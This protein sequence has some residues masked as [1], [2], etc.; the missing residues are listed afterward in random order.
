MKKRILSLLLALLMVVSMIP[1][2]IYATE[3]EAEGTPETVIQET[4]EP[5]PEPAPAPSQTPTPAPTETPAAPVAAAE[6]SPSPSQEVTPAPSESA[7][8][9]EEVTPAPTESSAPS[10]EE[11]PVPTDGVTASPVN[12]PAPTEEA[13]PSPSAEPEP[14]PEQQPMM[15]KIVTL[16]ANPGLL[17]PIE[18]PTVS[19]NGDIVGVKAFPER[20]KIEAVETVGNYTY[21]QLKAADGNWPDY[22]GVVYEHYWLPSTK[23]EEVKCPICEKTGCTKEHKKCETCGEY[24]CESTHENW[25]DICKKDD[26]GQNHIVDLTHESTGVAVY[27]TTFPEGVSLSVSSANVSGQLSTFGIPAS[28]QV[29]GLDISLMREDGTQYQPSNYVL[30]KVP[31][32][33]PAGTYVGILHT[34]NGNTTFLTFTQVLSDGT[35]EFYTR[36]FSEFAGFTVD[37]HYN[38]IDYSIGGLTSITLSE[39][40]PIL[41]IDRSAA[42]AVSVEFSDPTLISVTQIENDWRLES[43][44]A[45]DTEE[46]LTVTFADG[47]IIVIDVTD[48]KTSSFDFSSYGINA[49]FSSTGLGGSR[50]PYLYLYWGDNGS[51]FDHDQTTGVITNA[52]LAIYSDYY[53]FEIKKFEYIADRSDP[54]TPFSGELGGHPGMNAMAMGT[55]GIGGSP[56]VHVKVWDRTITDGTN[57][58]CSIEQAGEFVAKGDTI[59]RNVKIYLDG[60]E[61]QTISN[62]LFPHRAVGSDDPNGILASDLTTVTSNNSSYFKRGDV[63]GSATVVAGGDTYHVYLVTRGTVQYDANGGSGAP[64]SQY[65]Y[66]GV[67]LTL[68]STKPTKAYSTFKGWATTK[69]RADAGT[70]DYAAGATYTTNLSSGSSTTLYAVWE[71]NDANYTVKHMKQNVAGTGYDEVTGDRQTLTA[72][73]YAS[74]TPSVKSY[75]GFDSPATQTVTVNGDGSTVI[76]YK[77]NRKSYTVT[78][79]KG[80]GISAVSGGGTYKYGANVTVGATVSSG[81]TWKNWTSG[82]SQVSATQSYAFTMPAGNVTYTANAE[83][84]PYTIIYHLDNGTATNPGSY[85]IE[86][87]AFTLNNPEKTGYDFAGWT[88]TGLSGKTMTVTISKGSTGNRAYTANWTPKIF[89]VTLDDQG[90]TTSGTGEYWYKFNTVENGV[91]YYTNAAC[92]TALENYTITAPTKTGYDFAGY[93]TGKN[94]AGTQYINEDGVCVNNLYAAVADD[95]LLYAYWTPTEYTATFKDGAKTEKVSYDIE[96]DLSLSRSN[97]NKDG[98]VLS[99]KVTEAEGNWNT[100]TEYA[101]GTVSAGMYGDVTFTA[102]WTPISYTVRFTGGTGAT[103]TVSDISA[104]YDADVT[105]PDGS[106]LQRNITVTYVDRGETK[107]ESLTATFN[108][109]KLENAGSV[110]KPGDKVKNLTATANGVVTYYADWTLKSTTVP[111]IER[112]G[113]TLTWV[114]D[115]G[116]VLQPGDSFTPTQDVKLTAQWEAVV[117]TFTYKYAQDLVVDI[118]FNYDITDDIHLETPSREG[119]EFKGWKLENADG[120]NWDAKTYAGEDLQVGT[121]KYGNVVL[122]AQWEGLYNY[123]LK[124]DR[125]GGDENS[126]LP[127]EV[128]TGWVSESPKTFA[129]EAEENPTRENYDFKGWALSPDSTENVAGEGMNAYTVTGEKNQPK[130]VTLYAIWERQTGDLKLTFNGGETAPAIVT[131]SGE[132]LNITVVLTKAETVIQD[133]PTGAYTVT[134]VPGNASYTASV[135]ES[136]PQIK[137]GETTTVGVSTGSRG[138]NWFTAFFRVKNKCQ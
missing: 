40:F 91:Y 95:I 117:Y 14:T 16:V 93:Y 9:S 74:V 43:L 114:T 72:K 13:T 90:A 28:K 10:H 102:Q 73:A 59:R 105:L 111:N 48:Q 6:P 101:V 78:A 15:G 109:W 108:G 131:V 33:A 35:V 115:G 107:T 80:T 132:G 39:L 36:G 3:G 2:S 21:Y 7:A 54:Y 116:T 23:V 124:F 1:V 130:E 64:G 27:S 57:A 30:V 69:A 51:S 17:T 99:W 65:K 19:T 82:T 71:Y 104:Q 58:Y 96:R 125:N 47:E 85:N 53:W 94:G 81:Y 113:Y 32:S 37:F 77:Y 112:I 84:T 89:H 103:G 62:I 98:Y 136:N 60:A 5:S 29:F 66:N 50:K 118:V 135:T 49:Y 52:W 119:Y 41:E 123:T 138:L 68:S 126:P 106:G 61:K 120:T 38:N 4:P 31:V 25:C 46:T 110:V 76:E 55:F 87:A 67:N 127:E 88:G 97:F 75:T 26:C 121:G 8:P 12:S 128:V 133:L 63:G 44:Q 79:S 137:D 42:H 129:W 83:P 24:D 56:E 86:T 34:H 70:V 20:M 92:T 22:Y 18:D 134:A 45:F 11:E 122:V 100:G